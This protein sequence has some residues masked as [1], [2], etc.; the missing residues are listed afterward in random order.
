MLTTLHPVIGFGVGD[1]FGIEFGP[2]F[3]LRVFDQPAPN[4]PSDIGGFL[5]GADWDELS[6]YGRSSRR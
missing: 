6:D 4:R 5:R 2:T 3:R 1:D